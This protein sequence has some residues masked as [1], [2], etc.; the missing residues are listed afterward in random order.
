MANMISSLY[1]TLAQMLGLSSRAPSPVPAATAGNVHLFNSQ[2]WVTA[3]VEEVRDEL[4]GGLNINAKADNGATPLL[5]AAA[6]SG[7]PQVIEFLVDRGADV[8]DN[9]DRGWTVLHSAAVNGEPSH[10]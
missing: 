6:H 7:D 5:W 8:R 9:N 3:T 1:T 10:N 2:F 4:S